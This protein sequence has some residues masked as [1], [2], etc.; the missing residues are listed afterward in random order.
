MN[1]EELMASTPPMQQH[2]LIKGFQA[3]AASRDA[4]VAQWQNIIDEEAKDS[5]L[6]II[7]RDQLR[8]ELAAEQANN[9]RLRDFIASAQ[10]SSGVCCCGEAMD[11]HSSPMSCGHS[12]VDMWDH[13]V[14]KLL[15]APSDTSTLEAVAAI[16]EALA[17]TPEQS[18][19][20]Y[21][22]NVIEECASVCDKRS[23][24]KNDGNWTDFEL[25]SICGTNELAAD[26]IRAMKEQP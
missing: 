17:S 24:R 19:A 1:L 10:V 22:N 20:E 4:E 15:D 5:A 26:E 7:E 13:A 9:A 6:V 8:A 11:G 3:G 14:E 25:D 12:P 18:L 21:R 2:A 16:H 23:M